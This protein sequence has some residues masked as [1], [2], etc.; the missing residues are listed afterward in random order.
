MGYQHKLKYFIVQFIPLLLLFN[1]A[2]ACM[3]LHKG[4]VAYVM[5]AGKI[6]LDHMLQDAVKYLIF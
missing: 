5:Y 2:G 3:K 1:T 6:A 4:C